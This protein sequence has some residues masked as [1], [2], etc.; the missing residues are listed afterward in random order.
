MKRSEIFFSAMQLPIDIVMITLA[1]LSAYYVRNIPQILALRPKLYDITLSSFMEVVFFVAP[2]FVLIFAL[3]GLYQMRTTR[4]FWQEA[5]RVFQATSLVLVIV[6]VAIFLKREWFSSRF[7]ILA[8]WGF[9]VLYVI[10]GRYLIAR[11]QRY[12]LLKKGAGVHRVLLIGTNGKMQA[13][14]RYLTSHRELGYKIVA[15]V[16]GVSLHQIKE[17]RKEKGLDEVIVCDS[18]LTDDEHEKLLDYCQ[19]NNVSYRFIPTTLQTARVSMQIGILNGEPIIEYQH[20]P[21]DGWGKVMKRV[22]DLVAG[23]LLTL[24]ALPIMGIIALL[25]RLE[26]GDGP[27]RRPSRGR[28]ATRPRACARRP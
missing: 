28:P 16:S 2:I 6:I 24:L 11:I 12:Y 4:R 18:T 9:T 1:A 7:I 5:Y 19:I 14:K 13:M 15:Q 3:E 21:L 10:V 8:G 25:I 20:T 22:F 27:S 23:S 17:I 26:D